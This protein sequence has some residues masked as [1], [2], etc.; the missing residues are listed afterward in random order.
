MKEPY[1]EG[2]ANRLGPESCADGRKVAGEALTGEHA[3]Q[4][5][6]SEITTS[7]CRLSPYMGKATPRAASSEQPAGA[8]ESETLSMRES[9]VRENRETPETPTPVAGVGRSEKGVSLKSGMHVSGESDDSIV[10]TKRANNVGQPA[11]AEPVEGR[12]STK[13]NVLAVGRVP[14]A[15]PEE[16]VDRLQGVRQAANSA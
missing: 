2:V 14:D 11:T 8:A 5:L 10:P 15:V 16:R 9:S 1:K 4:P 3:G 12:G 13:G 6:S 7:A